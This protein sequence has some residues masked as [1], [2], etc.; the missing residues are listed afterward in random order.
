MYKGG[1]SCHV[2][3]SCRVRAVSNFFFPNP[4][5]TRNND[6]N[7]TRTRNGLTRQDTKLIRDT[8]LTRD[9]QLTR[10]WHEI[11]IETGSYSGWTRN[12]H[13]INKKLIRHLTRNWHEKNGSCS[14]STGPTRTRPVFSR[15]N[16]GWPEFDPFTFRVV[17]GSRNS[18]RFRF[19]SSCRDPNCH[20]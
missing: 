1:N 13:E 14:G 10:I 11:R 16:F 8:K 18:C 15:V 12:W 19:V 7:T 5:T 17:F 3:G 20:P 9:T 2:S 4:N 6:T